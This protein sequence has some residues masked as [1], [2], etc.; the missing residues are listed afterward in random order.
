MIA[1]LPEKP[2][3]AIVG[4]GAVGSYYGGRLVEHGQQVHWLLRSDYQHIKQHGMNIRSCRGDFALKPEQLHVYDSPELMPKADVVLVSLKTT[5]N[6][7]FSQLIS[8]LVST[9]TLILT[10]QNGLGN[11]QA[12]ADIFGRERII[13]GLAFV[14]INRISPGEIYHSDYGLI[15]IGEFGRG[16]TPR[17]RQLS[18]LFNHC[19]IEC[20]MLDNLMT[21]RWEKLI[22]N[23][24]FSGLGATMLLASDKIVG[25]E[26]GIDLARKLMGEVVMIAKAEGVILD[27]SLIDHNI[28]KTLAMGAYKSSMQIDRELGRSM[29]YEAIMGEPFRI[30]KRHNLHVPHIETLYRQLSLFRVITAG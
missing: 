4:A 18:A 6:R 22:W 19:G 14:C 27:D 25:C 2:R 13:G 23:V 8:P 9:D 10:L 12:L 15:K 11:E 1:K 29:E 26:A 28:K 3:F 17:L 7:H 24:P 16:I 20:Q 21:G 5:A 30:A